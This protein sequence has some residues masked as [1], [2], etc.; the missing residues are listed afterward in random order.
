VT[1]PGTWT[2][3]SN[4]GKTGFSASCEGRVSPE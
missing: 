1:P 4:L 2:F 3:L